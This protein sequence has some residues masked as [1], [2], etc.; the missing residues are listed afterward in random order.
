MRP[1]SISY[2]VTS[3][4]WASLSRSSR[5]CRS[6]GERH[7]PCQEPSRLGMD[8]DLAWLPRQRRHNGAYEPHVGGDY[9][10]AP[11][12][13]I[14]LSHF[15]WRL[16]RWISVAHAIHFSRAAHSKRHVVASAGHH[17]A[18][19]VHHLA[20]YLKIKEKRRVRLYQNKLLHLY[21]VWCS[22][23]RQGWQ[24]WNDTAQDLRTR[25]TSWPSAAYGRPLLS[26][27]LS[28]S[29]AGAPAV[30]TLSTATTTPLRS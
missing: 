29:A 21:S 25:A 5:S 23:Q 3:R 18:R 11:I 26:S 16:I 9:P 7:F 10:H 17:A 19:G 12:R 22:C 27:R 6:C 8:N 20:A 13:Q 4:V 14:L 24:R 15:V 30:I 1:A 28:C 2:A